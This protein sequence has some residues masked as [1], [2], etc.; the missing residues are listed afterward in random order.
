MMAELWDLDG[1]WLDAEAGPAVPLSE[2]QAQALVARASA[3]VESRPGAGR[4][5]RPWFWAGAT[6]L[7]AASAAAAAGGLRFWSGP[8]DLPQR[9]DTA[10]AAAPAGGGRALEHNGFRWTEPA[11][12]GG[13][14]QAEDTAAEE[15]PAPQPRVALPPASGQRTAAAPD[16]RAA[17]TAVAPAPWVDRLERASAARRSGKVDEALAIYQSI[18]HDFPGTRQARVARLSAAEIL[19]ARGQA[20]EAAPMFAREEQ[21]PS[22]GALF[23]LAGARRKLGDKNGERAALRRLVELYPDSSLASAARSRLQELR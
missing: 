23:G 20:A 7:V 9:V 6:I 3:R 1:T 4:V 11:S 8:A 10:R 13:L 16:K 19:L 2:E 18:Q 12:H 14:P 17:R 15:P 21:G 22:A 5:I